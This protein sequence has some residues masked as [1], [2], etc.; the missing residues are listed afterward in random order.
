MDK[1]TLEASWGLVYGVAEMTRDFLFDNKNA[2]DKQT[3]LE[4]I[5]DAINELE[6]WKKA[7]LEL[8]GEQDGV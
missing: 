3:T 6:S 1:Q 5:D 4:A 2:H 7:V 8:G